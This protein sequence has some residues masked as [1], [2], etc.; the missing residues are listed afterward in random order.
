MFFRRMG[1]DLHAFLYEPAVGHCGPNA[2]MTSAETQ[3][4]VRYSA[5]QRGESYEMLK[6]RMPKMHN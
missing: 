1:Q 2:K 5:A 4:D 6:N 3:Y